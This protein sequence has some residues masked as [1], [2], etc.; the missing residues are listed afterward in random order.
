[1]SWQAYKNLNNNS[2]VKEYNISGEII[3]IRFKNSASWGGVVS[4]LYIYSGQSCGNEAMQELKRLAIQGY[5]LN[6]YIKKNKIKY[7]QR[8]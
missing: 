2:S 4:D 7:E 8:V 6:S 3:A 1:M 5:G